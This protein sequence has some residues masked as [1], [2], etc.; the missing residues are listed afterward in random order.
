MFVVPEMNMFRVATLPAKFCTS[1]ILLGDFMLTRVWIFFG[2]APIPLCVTINPRNLPYLTPKAHLEGLRDIPF[3][4]WIEK[5]SL[6][7]AT[8]FEVS[9]LV[10]ACKLF[11]NLSSIYISMVLWI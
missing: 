4:L 8:W 9:N 6:R 1:F 2:L 10:V 7:S 5:A 3:F 11:T